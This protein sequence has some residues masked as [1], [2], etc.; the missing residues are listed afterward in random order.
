VRTEDGKALATQDDLDG[1]RW[2]E[3]DKGSEVVVRH[4]VS[5]RELS[6]FGPGRAWPCRF[7]QEQVLLAEGKLESSPGTGVRPGAEVWVA[8][9]FGSLRYADAKLQLT[10]SRDGLQLVVR[11]GQAFTESIDGVRAARD[12]GQVT[13]PNGRA[14]VRGRPDPEAAVKSCEHAAQLA[15]ESAQQVLK[16]KPEELGKL[17][18][19][20][21]RTRRL[22]RGRCLAA[23]ASV[24]GLADPVKKARLGDQVQ[25]ADA[26]W[27]GVPAAPSKGL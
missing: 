13:G 5:A 10:S 9:P 24:A 23:E 12:D 22:A 4:G 6:L 14:T 11:S 27:Q 19:A 7:G 3:L 17:A 26:Q 8:T 20:Q 1:A 15:S 16:A 18:A 21:L 2:L 25:R